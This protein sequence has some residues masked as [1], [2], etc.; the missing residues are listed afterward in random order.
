MP[1][2]WRGWWG[3][4][5]PSPPDQVRGRLC[6]LPQ[7]CADRG[8]HEHMFGDM[9]NTLGGNEGMGPCRSRIDR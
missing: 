8:H 3:W 7:M 5:P 2:I 4:Q 1:L 6:P 9:V